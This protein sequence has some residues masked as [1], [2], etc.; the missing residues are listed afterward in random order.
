MTL[1]RLPARHHERFLADWTGMTQAEGTLRGT[2]SKGCWM[3]FHFRQ[4]LV[5]GV[6]LCGS[7][8]HC[9]PS[10]RCCQW[11]LW[12]GPFLCRSTTPGTKIDRQDPRGASCDCPKETCAECSLS[13]SSWARGQGKGTQK[14]K[15]HSGKITSEEVPLFPVASGLTGFPL[16]LSW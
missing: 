15:K 16:W 2:L 5:A 4:R 14:G 6:L 10:P 12:W 9:T 1:K 7:L 8:V 13:D 11:T 3:A